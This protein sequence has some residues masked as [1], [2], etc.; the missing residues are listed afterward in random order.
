MI[1]IIYLQYL[2]T[3]IYLEVKIAKGLKD[4]LRVLELLVLLF[5]FPE[6][7][8]FDENSKNKYIV[9]KDTILLKYKTLKTIQSMCIYTGCLLLV[10]AV[11]SYRHYIESFY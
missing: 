9:I 10:P 4:D 3:S 5:K 8:L 11:S 1:K 7:W 6:N 2:I